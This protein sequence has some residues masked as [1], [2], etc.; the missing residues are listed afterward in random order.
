MKEIIFSKYSNERSRSFAIRTDIVEE[1]GKRWL[2]KKWLYPEGKEHVLRMKKWNQKLDQMYGEVPFLSNKCEI[3][4]DCAYFE[5]LEQENLA[6]YLDDLLGKG[7][8]G[9]KWCG[10]YR[11]YGISGK[12]TEASQQ[13]AVH[14]N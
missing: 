3:G 11:F 10:S 14:N 1:D 4:E 7:E 8:L 5:Y 6:E 2:E 12:R 13:K 9:K